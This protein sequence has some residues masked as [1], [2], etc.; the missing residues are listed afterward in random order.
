MTSKFG[1]AVTVA[2]LGL[3]VQG[4]WA[5]PAANLPIP[6]IEPARDVP[7]AHL[8]PNPSTTYKVVFDVRAAAKDVGDV[9]PGLVAVARYVNTLAK[10]GVPAEHRKIAA[11]IHRNA[12]EIILNDAAFKAR[13]D[14]H[15]NPNLE[16]I[17]TLKRAGVDLHVCGQAV[18][19]YKIEP[20]TIVPEIQ[21]DL[22]AF[23]TFIELQQQG[24]IR[25]GGG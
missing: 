16:L 11:V 4:A 3:V 23:T 10:Y 19:A 5:Q 22:W 14:G 6:G 18:L 13:H 21:L 9:N 8:V 2:L 24:Y 17:R 15:D 25:A 20:K 1:R 12:T 7:G